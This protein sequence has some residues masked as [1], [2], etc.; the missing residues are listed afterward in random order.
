[1]HLD[2][3]RQLERAGYTERQ[4]AFD[5]WRKEF[6]E[7]RPHEALGM[8]FPCEVYRDSEKKYEGTPEKLVYPGIESR[9]VKADGKVSFEGKIYFLST[10]LS[11]WDVGLA[12]VAGGR[13]EVRFGRLVLGHLETATESFQPIVEQ[14]SQEM[15]QAA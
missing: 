8:Q 10:A 7:E 5:L 13:W 15:P 3:S 6:N 11:G 14:T 1:M 9:R 12:P 4:A 2:I